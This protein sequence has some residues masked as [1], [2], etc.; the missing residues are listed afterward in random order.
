MREGLSLVKKNEGLESG[1][2][3]PHG[4]PGMK[5]HLYRV[6][7]WD[8]GSGEGGYVLQIMVLGSIRLAVRV[9]LYFDSCAAQNL[10]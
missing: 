4:E 5:V 3:V 8:A 1:P 9:L 7:W 10:I 6:G 2:I